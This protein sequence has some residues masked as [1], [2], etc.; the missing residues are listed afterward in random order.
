MLDYLIKNARIVD[1]TGAP[2]YTGS[3]SVAAG[4]IVAAC[5]NEPANRVGKAS[6]RAAPK[7]ATP[8]RRRLLAKSGKQCDGMT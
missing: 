2:S 4:K 8:R 6:R 1:G 7:F 3:I 5:G